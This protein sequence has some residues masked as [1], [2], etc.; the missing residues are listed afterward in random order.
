MYS[1]E[2]PDL[3]EQLG[4]RALGQRVEVAGQVAEVDLR[5][6]RLGQPVAEDC[7]RSTSGSKAARE[8]PDPARGA[9]DGRVHRGGVAAGLREEPR[10]TGTGGDGLVE[11][12]HPGRGLDQRR[13]HR[14]VGDRGD[15]LGDRLERVQRRTTQ[16]CG[17]GGDVDQ[18]PTDCGGGLSHLGTVL[19][20]VGD[21]LA[22]PLGLRQPGGPLVEVAGLDPK[23][24]GEV[25]VRGITAVTPG[26]PRRTMSRNPSSR[27]S[28]I[29]S[30]IRDGST[31]NSCASRVLGTDTTPRAFMLSAIRS[32]STRQPLVIPSRSE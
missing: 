20:Q 28:L 25:L 16:G 14:G 19:L 3:V 1:S 32:S 21:E 4:V 9:G 24:R 10:S 22:E 7:G 31:P 15:G 8:T 13:P 2:L 11:Q 29:R 6:G 17:G 30:V 12:D 27:A 5:A 26:L 23:P 18:R